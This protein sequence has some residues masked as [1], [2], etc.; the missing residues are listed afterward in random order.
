MCWNADISLNT[1]LFSSFLLALVIY[2]N[3]YT[4]YKIK[5]LNNKWIYLF[6]ASFI[7]MQLIEFFIWRN[8]NNKFYNSIFSSCA[9]LL[10]II[11]PVASLMIINNIKVRNLL[12]FIYLLFSIP[13]LLY[14]FSST[15]HIYSTVSKNGHLIWNF[16]GNRKSIFLWFFWSFWL[17]FFLFSLFYEKFYF[18]FLFGIITLLISLIN[19]INDDTIGSMW[20]WVV[21]SIMIY[22]AFYLLIYLPFL[23]KSKLC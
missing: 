14:N 15:K 8:I 1:F 12:L 20:C 2:N 3:S 17:F 16:F 6:F 22:Y 18:G 19:Y 5:D 21:N 13:Y 9:L 23:E 4:R 11:Q 10:L 7:L